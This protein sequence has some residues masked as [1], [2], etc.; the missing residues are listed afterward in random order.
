MKIEIE[1]DEG[2]L[3]ELVRQSL[4]DSYNMAKNFG[5]VDYEFT[6]ALIKVIEYYSDFD[7]YQEFQ[8]SINSNVNI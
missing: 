7:E 5:G 6:Q 1:L 3:D 4:I 2:Q 8:R